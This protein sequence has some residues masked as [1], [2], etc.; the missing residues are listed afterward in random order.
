MIER[1]NPVDEP[2]LPEDSAPIRDPDPAP[3]FP[4]PP[5][6]DHATRPK[7][8]A[9]NPKVTPLDEDKNIEEGIEVNET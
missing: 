7:S 2:E 1:P 9:N 5:Q 6:A 4:K 8:P 3:D